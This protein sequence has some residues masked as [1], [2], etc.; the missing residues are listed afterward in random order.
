[1]TLLKS[2][3]MPVRPWLS[4]ERVFLICE[5]KFQHAQCAESKGGVYLHCKISAGNELAAS[6]GL[7]RANTSSL[8]VSSA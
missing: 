3:Q 5:S 7:Q 1:M 6:R 2:A 4:R 8:L